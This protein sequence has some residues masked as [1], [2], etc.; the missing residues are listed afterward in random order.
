VEGRNGAGT[1][2]LDATNDIAYAKSLDRAGI[3]QSETITAALKLTHIL[4]GNSFYDVNINYFNNFDIPHM[5]PIFKHNIAAYG[6]SIENAKVGTLLDSDG[7][8]ATDYNAYGWDFQKLQPWDAYVKR[9]QIA[10][11]INANFL[12]QLGRHNEIKIG[13]EYK[14]YTIRNYSTGQPMSIAS[15]AR[16]VADRDPRDVYSRLDNYGYDIYGNKSDSGLDGPRHPVFAGLYLQDKLEYADLIIN[17]GIRFDYYF[18]DSEEFV[19]PNNVLFDENDRIDPSSLK[20]V[21]AFT[22]VSPRLGFS[23]PVTERTIFHAQYGRFFQQSRL[24]DIYQGYNLVADNIKGGFAI[25]NPVGFGLKPE[26][27]TQYELGFKQ[28]L[29]NNFAFDLTLFYKDIKDQVQQRSIYADAEANHLQYY[30]WVNGDFETIKGFEI[31][32]DL[33]R[34]SRIAGSIDYT[35]S[36]ALGTGSNP[37]SSFRSIWQSPTAEPFFPQQIAPVTFNQTHRGS[38]ILDYRFGVGDGGV[39]ERSGVNL[40]FQF[41]SGFNYTRWNGFAQARTPVESLNYSTTPWTYRLDMKI[42]KS[43]TFGPVDFN[44]Y[45]WITNVLNT[46]N[47]VQV[48]NTSGDAYDDGWL[49]TNEGATRSDAYAQYGEQYRELHDKIYR[50]MTYDPTFFDPP[51]QIRLGLRLDY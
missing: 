49:A 8:P 44:V 11:G 45:L 3:N 10:Y 6:D 40:L 34:T 15:L 46:Q 17:A 39:M 13:G 33:R 27:T 22:Q 23:F 48:F 26:R 9:R 47:V 37:S 38:V 21:P 35:F 31:K 2:G 12:Y 4:S 18:T 1:E 5:D 19:N 50:A 14:I 28:Q 43:F 29:G 36:D 25:Q 41:T 16:T 20:D 30:A 24:R 32:M 51:R 42:D 7:S